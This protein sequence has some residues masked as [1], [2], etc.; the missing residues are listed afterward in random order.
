L[1]A[2]PRSIDAA[3]E[4]AELKRSQSKFD[5]AIDYYTQA[6]QIGR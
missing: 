1:K 2:N 3:T 6:A 4:L 5:E